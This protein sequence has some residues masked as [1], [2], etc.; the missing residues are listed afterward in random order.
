MN[1]LTTMTLQ[2]VPKH[3]DERLLLEGHQ[4]AEGKKIDPS[5]VFWMNA[6]FLECNNCKLRAA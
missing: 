5:S 6:T 4:Q 3:F 1:N 2:P